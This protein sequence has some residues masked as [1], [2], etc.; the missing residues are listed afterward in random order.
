MQPAMKIGILGTGKV[1][2]TLATKLV[3]L[4]HDVKM[5][6]RTSDN[7]DA[8]DWA[9]KNGSRASHGTFTDAAS[10]VDTLVFNCTPGTVSIDALKLAGDQYLRGKVLVDVSNGTDFSKGMPP[11]LP[12]Y[13][14]DSVGE[15]IQRAFPDTKVVKTLNTMRAGLMVNPSTLSEETDVFVSGN[16]TTAKALVTSLLREFGWNRVIDLGDIS[17]A[18]GAEMYFALW[19]RLSMKFQNPIFNI[20]IVR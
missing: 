11:S 14:T 17:T 1:G 18:R 15:Q 13:N 5:G 4:G 7:E 2:N 8:T 3:K 19:M 9:D 16:D 10:Y 12:F 6:S 20:R